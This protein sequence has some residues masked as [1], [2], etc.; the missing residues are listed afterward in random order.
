M[1]FIQYLNKIIINVMKNNQE[2]SLNILVAKHKLQKNK[3][4]ANFVKN[5]LNVLIFSLELL[6]KAELLKTYISVDRIQ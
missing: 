6:Y 1:E 5:S 2:C 3:L 4:T